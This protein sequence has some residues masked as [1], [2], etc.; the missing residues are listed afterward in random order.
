MLSSPPCPHHK[1]TPLRV[2]FL[3]FTIV[4]STFS[5]AAW[6]HDCKLSDH[7]DQDRKLTS[8]SP[9]TYY[10]CTATDTDSSESISYT[11]STDQV[12]QNT[13]VAIPGS[14]PLP[15]RFNVVA[16]GNPQTGEYAMVEHNRN[17]IPQDVLESL[18]EQ[19]ANELSGVGNCGNHQSFYT[20]R[21][22][23]PDEELL[24]RLKKFTD[25]E[26][27]QSRASNQWEEPPERSPLFRHWP[28]IKKALQ[29][30]ANRA[31]MSWPVVIFSSVLWDQPVRQS[32][33]RFEPNPTNNFKGCPVKILV[34]TNEFLGDMYRQGITARRFTSR[35]T[36]REISEGFNS[37]VSTFQTTGRFIDFLDESC[38]CN[39]CPGDTA[40]HPARF[41]DCL[42]DVT[43]QTD[44]MVFDALRLTNSNLNDFLNAEV[45]LSGYIAE[46][47]GAAP[48]AKTTVFRINS[49]IKLNTATILHANF[50]NFDKAPDSSRPTCSCPECPPTQTTS[51]KNAGTILVGITNL[52]ISVAAGATI[53]ATVLVISKVRTRLRTG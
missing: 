31:A 48:Q 45:P 46:F 16:L 49:D 36:V 5:L 26:L 38:Q 15:N 44:V 34:D 52:A 41:S 3:F 12:K 30:I 13:V 28:E 17:P 22:K 20:Y 18:A 9:Y 39:T 40:P 1:K 23:S 14:T 6:N 10:L 32:V 51:S 37:D 27:K 35:N 11:L 21:F 19:A 53:W 29:S 42:V 50:S 8:D 43:I 47:N 2:L 4:T 33:A 7:Q 25:K 24:K